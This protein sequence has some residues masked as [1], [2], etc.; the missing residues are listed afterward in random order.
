MEDA[1]EALLAYDL[2]AAACLG[3]GRHEQALDDALRC[4]TLNPEW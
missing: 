1:P 4:T 2:R 3:A